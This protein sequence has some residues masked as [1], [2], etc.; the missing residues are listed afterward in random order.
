MV[1]IYI[2]ELEN[3]KFY[4]G[5]TEHPDIRIDSHFQNEGSIWTKKYKPIRIQELI[6]DC[7]SFDEDKH[8]LKLM[9]EKGINN[10][11]GGSF[12]QIKLNDE[13]MKTIQQMLVSTNDQCFIC[14]SK[15]HFMKDC[16]QKK[17]TDPKCDCASSYFS[18]HRKSKCLLKKVLDLFDDEEEEVEKIKSYKCFRC[19]REG[20]FIKNCY[21]STHI[22]G[23]KLK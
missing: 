2:L 20:H 19:G 21:A 17:K 15:E 7:D 18:P 10:V 1:F 8:V 14:G 22:N 23:N 13:N 12:S 3:Q 4:V 9:S 6:P 5:K 11:R 16:K